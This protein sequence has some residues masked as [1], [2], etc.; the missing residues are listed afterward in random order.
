MKSFLSKTKKAWRSYFDVHRNLEIAFEQERQAYLNRATA[1]GALLAACLVPFFSILDAVFK[2][3][4][5]LIFLYIRIATTLFAVMI[6]TLTR[7]P[8]GRRYSYTLGAV[9]TL[10]VAG[11]IAIMCRLDQ[12]PA[13]PYYAGI[14]LPILGFGMLL[15]MTIFEGAIIF[16]IAWMSYF[17]PNVLILE[18]AQIPIFVSNN[19][20]M[21]SSI[22]I[23]LASSQFHLYHRRSAWLA[24][25]ELKKA[26]EKIQHH[27]ENLEKQ[28]K[29]R[30]Q[31]LIQSERLAV[32]GQLAGGIA[33]DFNNILTAILGTSQLA[34]IS[35]PKTHPVREDLAA[36][37]HVGERAVN[38]VKQL[39]A[40]S[41]KQV[42]QPHLINLNDVIEDIRKMLQRLIG[43]NIVLNV[44]LNDNI[45]NVMADPIQIEQILLNLAVNA[46]DAMVDGGTLTIQTCN[47]VL[48]EAYCRMGKLALKPGRYVRMT[49]IDTGQGMTEEV[50]AKIF[51][52]FFTT[53]RKGKGTGLGLASVY[54]IVR[55]SKG[56]IIA[57]SEPGKGSSFKVYLPLVDACPEMEKPVKMPKYRAVKTGKETILLVE[58][59]LHV[60]RLTARILEKQG[61]TV[62]QAEEGIS[63]LEL[64]RNY[65]G[66]IDMLLTDI[67]MPRMNGPALAERIKKIRSDIKI[68]FM[69]GHVDSIIMRHGLEKTTSNFLQ[70][71]Y[72]MESLNS[73]VRTVFGN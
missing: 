23:A 22:L 72:T 32:V 16:T 11:S 36:I 27:A 60:R 57:Y 58:D 29:E 24:N 67:I 55:Q 12:G 26:N 13:D 7:K 38:L 43:E 46:R 1:I 51:E 8:L 34:L 53:K 70:K 40:F 15:P 49:F 5:F 14:N 62:L 31:R 71:P 48:D 3:D 64:A 69:S 37:Y 2:P 39:L 20:F 63:A 33:H 54:G 44:E 30:S 65:E 17:I 41:R 35:L 59:E 6:F 68:L 9:L 18:P 10:V 45:G 25:Q 56:D 28:V 61:Y 47:A 52:P 50:R 73:K 4:H 42:L 66:Q 19:F 21:L